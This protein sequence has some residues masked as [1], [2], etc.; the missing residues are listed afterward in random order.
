MRYA[1]YETDY[2]PRVNDPA[3]NYDQVPRDGSFA[4][5]AGTKPPLPSRL[6]VFA[7]FFVSRAA[8]HFTHPSYISHPS[9]NDLCLSH[10]QVIRVVQTSFDRIPLTP[11]TAPSRL[12]ANITACQPPT[13]HVPLLPNKIDDDEKHVHQTDDDA[14]VLGLWGR[15]ADIYHHSACEFIVLYRDL[16]GSWMG[17]RLR[18]R[19]ELGSGL[20]GIGRG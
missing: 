5:G 1:R 3:R 9:S 16:G 18:L 15:G 14:V 2:A 6:G 10:S 4:A 17:L 11:S 7:L 20:V 8:I 19:L 12:F 13:D